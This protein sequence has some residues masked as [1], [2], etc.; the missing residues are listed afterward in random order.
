MSN[1]LEMQFAFSEDVVTFMQW[2]SVECRY[3]IA[4]LDVYKSK[5]FVYYVKVFKSLSNNIQH[6]TEWGKYLSKTTISPPIIA[7]WI[8][9]N[10]TQ[11]LMSGKHQKHLAN[12]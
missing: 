8:L 11:L 5:P 10:Q 4:E 12:C 9:M 2:E 7:P 6:Y 3:G 1:I